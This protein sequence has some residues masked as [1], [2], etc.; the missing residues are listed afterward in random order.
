MNSV[1]EKSSVVIIA[2][3]VN[4]S[5]F[6]P[7]WLLKNKVFLE[8][9]L[10]GNVI[11]T[12]PVVQIATDHFQFTALPDR[13]QL[14]LHDENLSSEK[15]IER[16][17]GTIVK[18]LPHTPYTAVGLNFNYL[19]APEDERQFADWNRNIFTTPL[20]N[21]ILLNDDQSTDLGAIYPSMP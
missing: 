1:H 18:T 3:D 11:F 6:K 8:R 13:V 17:L 5:I 16:V 4:L 10:E 12:P 7:P 20:S 9:E 15:D 14:F 2:K 21:N 19:I